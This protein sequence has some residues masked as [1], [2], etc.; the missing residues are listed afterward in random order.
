[1]SFYTTIGISC[2]LIL[3]SIL[4]EPMI[5]YLYVFRM[6]NHDRLLTTEC[7]G[8]KDDDQ[9]IITQEK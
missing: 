2:S 1:M 3:V 6:I 8:P 5:Q 4:S 7:G 9:V